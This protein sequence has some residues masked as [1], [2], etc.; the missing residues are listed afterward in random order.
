[1]RLLFTIA[2]MAYVVTIPIT[3]VIYTGFCPYGPLSFPFAFSTFSASGISGQA[4]GVTFSLFP[5][6]VTL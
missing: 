3:V 1:M 6:F 5:P 4:V 2:F